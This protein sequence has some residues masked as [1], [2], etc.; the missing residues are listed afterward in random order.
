MAASCFPLKISI[1]SIQCSLL[2]HGNCGRLHFSFV[3]DCGCA[4]VSPAVFDV[5][6]APAATVVNGYGSWLL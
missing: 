5:A 6:E 1:C 2:E 4:R 3:L